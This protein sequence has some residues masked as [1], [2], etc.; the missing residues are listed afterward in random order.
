MLEALGL[1]RLL[2]T[3]CPRSLLVVFGLFWPGIWLPRTRLKGFH[4]KMLFKRMCPM[5]FIHES[6]YITSPWNLS[7]IED[8]AKARKADRNY[9]KNKN[10][11]LTLCWQKQRKATR[12]K[13]LH[14]F[15]WCWFKPSPQFQVF[16]ICPF[17]LCLGHRQSC[18]SGFHCISD[19]TCV[20]L[21]WGEA[22]VYISAW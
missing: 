11:G 8:R 7:S 22:W 3:C 14:I 9:F 6:M 17:R 1:F 20:F 19:F 13:L 5:V 10:S 15:G 18:A 2:Q 21:I 16:N 12:P 4:A